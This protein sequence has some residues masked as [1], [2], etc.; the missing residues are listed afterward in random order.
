MVSIEERKIS[1][2]CQRQE[3]NVSD[4][5]VINKREVSNNVRNEFLSFY[6]VKLSSVFGVVYHFFPSF[7]LCVFMCLC[8]CVYVCVRVCVCVCVCLSV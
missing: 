6:E 1:I 5:T 2:S 4:L 8:I 3:R 7:A